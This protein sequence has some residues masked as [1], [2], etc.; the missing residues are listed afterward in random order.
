[1]RLGT[2]DAIMNAVAEFVGESKRGVRE[3]LFG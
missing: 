1:M 3:K 2:L